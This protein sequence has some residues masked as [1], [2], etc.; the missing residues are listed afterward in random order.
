MARPRFAALATSGPA[1]GSIPTA[2]TTT[3]TAAA[4]S[5]PTVEATMIRRG[6]D[7]P[8]PGGSGDRNAGRRP[9][10]GGEVRAGRGDVGAG[11]GE[12]RAGRGDVGGG[13]DP[14]LERLGGGRDRVREAGL[15]AR[16]GPSQGLHAGRRVHAPPRGTCAA[17][18]VLNGSGSP[19][20]SGGV[21]GATA[22]CLGRSL[23]ARASRSSKAVRNRRR[24]RC[25]RPRAVIARQPMT[26]AISAG[27]PLPLRQQ[28]DLAI[29]R[30]QATKRLVHERLL[31][32]VRGR[33]LHL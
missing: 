4:T 16:A 30:P 29:M 23:L 8:L 3:T 32:L 26:T 19:V 22:S 20:G 5:V 21:G 12:V 11:G 33:F 13:G 7:R 31:R 18:R 17:G 14:C 10:A 28:Q 2:R 15:G 1:P 24:A 25:R 6:M 27:E 9:G